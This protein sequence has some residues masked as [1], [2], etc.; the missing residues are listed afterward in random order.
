[1]DKN[2]KNI[3]F[4]L[5]GV[6]INLDFKR[7]L[8]AFKKAGFENIENQLQSFNREGIFDQYELGNIS[9]EEFRAAIRKQAHEELTDSEIDEMWNLILLDIP[10]EK[11]KL[12]LDLRSKYMVYLLSNT[13]Q[14]H[15]EY[16]CQ[17][18]FTYHGFRVN[19]Y[20]EKTFLSFEMHLAKPDK[21]IFEQMLHEANLLSEET[22]F[23]DDSE[24]NCKAAAE[25]GIHAHHYH[26]GDDLSK[27]FE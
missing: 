2:I 14:I 27:I 25:V 3:V 26:I 7:A 15:W 12:I 24:A 22:L 10:H 8:D 16:T 17:N 4:D 9:S 21:Q 6:L 11:L 20:F 18:A 19:D 5:G 23:I 1:M 13:N